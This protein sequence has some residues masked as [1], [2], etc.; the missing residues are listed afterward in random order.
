MPYLLNWVTAVDHLFLKIAVADST[1]I[2]L[3][4]YATLDCICY[5][6][7]NISYVGSI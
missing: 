6:L 7:G 4:A 2:A 1:L 3:L 5:R